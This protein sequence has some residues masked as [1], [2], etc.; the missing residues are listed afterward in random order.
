MRVFLTGAAGFIGFHTARVLLTL[1]HEVFGY[2]SVNDYYDP[3]FKEARLQVLSDHQS[4][5]FTRA[6]LEDA[7]ALRKVWEK[8][9]PEVVIHLAAQAGV[10]YSLENPMAYISANVVGFQNI[11]EL[12]RETRPRNLVYASSSSVYGGNKELPFA[13]SQKIQDPISLYAATKAANELVAKCYGNLFQLPSVGLRFFT[14]YGPFSRPDMAMFKFAELIRTGKPIPV[15]N[16]GQMIRDFTYIDDIVDGIIRSM[17]HNELGG[18]YNLG[19]GS[20]LNLMDM[21]D[22]LQK[23]LGLTATLDMLPMQLG[24]VP[25]TI[26]DI[27]KAKLILG[28]EPKIDHDTGIT[29]FANWYREFMKLT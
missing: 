28:Y 22:L 24:D 1:G 11:I 5:H 6:K 26:A 13:E 15:Y 3:A 16:N 14:V 29:H 7:Q 17:R 27:S 18:V 8:C 25:A 4:F 23:K 20:P 10:R 9:D 21:I 19:R 2:D 12:A